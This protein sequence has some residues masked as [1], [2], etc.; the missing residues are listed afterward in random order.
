MRPM[1]EIIG[2][3]GITCTQCPV[4]EATQEDDD[5]EREKWAKTYTRQ[6]GREYRP[7][8]INCDGCPTDG[9]RIF[10]FCNDCRIRDCARE[11]NVESCAI[12]EDYPCE[13]LASVISKTRVP[14]RETLE[15][16]RRDS[17][18]LNTTEH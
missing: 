7:E 2:Y 4:Y 9:T 13:T 18:R 1:G 6:Y 10:R 17:N 14:A 12:C 5:A 3:C 15:K 8:D 16:I 11:K